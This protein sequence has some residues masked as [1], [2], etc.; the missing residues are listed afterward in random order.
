MMASK[1]MY[2][3]SILPTIS[4][5]RP[6]NFLT[7]FMTFLDFKKIIFNEIW[8]VVSMWKHYS[9]WR[10]ANSTH[11]AKLRNAQLPDAILNSLLTGDIR[12][13]LMIIMN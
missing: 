2:L 12:G 10:L 1:K 13:Y 6:S 5:I 7:I 11:A 4:T 9:K 3:L 8:T